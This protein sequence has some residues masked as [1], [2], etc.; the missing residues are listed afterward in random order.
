MNYYIPLTAK[1]LDSYERI[2]K[3]GV[4]G[5]NMKST[6]D[7]IEK[8]LSTLCEAY[9]QQLD[10]LYSAEAMDISSDIDVLKKIMERD[11]FDSD[12]PFEQTDNGRDDM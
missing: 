2:E 5:E 9:R 7:N 10:E 3:S 8:T 6:V 11:G 4:I 1:L 12:S